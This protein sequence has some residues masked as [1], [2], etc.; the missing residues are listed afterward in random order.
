L[1][2]VLDPVERKRRDVGEV[3]EDIENDDQSAPGQQRT[4]EISARIADLA[5]DK[6]DVRPGC[7]GEEGA[8]HCFAKKKGEGKTANNG[9]TRL[10]RLWTPAVFP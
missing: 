2:R 3:G 4:R 6:G 1:R 5:S 7:L 8:Y 9:E 10:R